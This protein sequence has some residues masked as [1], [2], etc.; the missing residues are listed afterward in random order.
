MASL[1]L[2]AG[3]TVRIDFHCTEPNVVDKHNK[4]KV[5]PVIHFIE[6]LHAG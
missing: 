3:R 2:L 6:S 1:S 5:D 4:K